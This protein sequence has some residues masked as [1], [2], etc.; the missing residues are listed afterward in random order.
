MN[1]I[2]YKGFDK[3][4]LKEQGVKPLVDNS[5]DDKFNLELLVESGYSEKIVES[6]FLKKDLDE[7]YITYEE[8]VV[9]YETLVTPLFAKHKI[10]VKN[11]NLYPDIYPI[12]VEINKDVFEKYQNAKDSDKDAVG[13]DKEIRRLFRFYS[14]IYYVNGRFYVSYHNNEI[15][16]GHVE[17]VDYYDNDVVVGESD[18][19]SG[20]DYFFDICDEPERYIECLDELSDKETSVIAYRDVEKTEVTKEA[21][22][23]LKAFCR[24][25]DKK[26]IKLIDAPNSHVAVRNELFDIT[27]MMIESNGGVFKGFKEFKIYKNPKISNETEPVS[28]G[29]VMEIIAREAENAAEGRMYRDIFFTAPTGAGKSM[30][31]QAPA[32]YIAD[33]YGKL[34]IIIEPLKSLMKDQVD[35]LRK[36]YGNKVDYINSDVATPADRD[37]IIEGIKNGRINI[38]YVSPETLISRT[39][40]S[41]VGEREIG[42]L[43][44]DEAHIVTAW[45]MG[46]RPDYWYL[47]AYINRLR[48]ERNG[49]GIIKEG[50]RIDKF[51]IFAC[52]ATAVNGG[53]DDT[54]SET[55]ISLTMND[56]IV[57]L[58]Y[59]RRDDDIKFDIR[60]HLD[61]KYTKNEYRVDKADNLETSLIKWHEDGKKTIIYTPYRSI[62]EKMKNASGEFESFQKFSDLTGIYTGGGDDPNQKNEEMDNF[63]AG[64]IKTMFA[65]KAFGMGVDIKDVD[66]VYHYA[67]TGSLADYVQEIGRVARKEGMI[68]LATTD[69]YSHDME[70]IDA[71]YGMSQITKTHIMQCLRIIYDAY[72]QKGYRQRFVISPSMFNSV[73]VAGRNEDRDKTIEAKLKIALLMIEKDLRNTY[74][75]PV[76]VSRPGTVFTNSYVQVAEP[77]LND[78][79]GSKYS[80]YFTEKARYSDGLNKYTVFEVNLSGI[81]EDERFGYDRMSFPEFKYH[82]YNYKNE[83]DPD[84]KVMSEISMYYIPQALLNLEAKA[85]GVEKLYDLAKQHIG[86]VIEC[87]STFGGRYF[88]I[89]EFSKKL[90]SGSNAMKYN[91]MQA[92]SIANSFFSVVDPYEHCVRSRI[93]PKNQIIEYSVTNGNLRNM[94]EAILEQSQLIRDMMKSYGEKYSRFIPLE[95]KKDSDALKLLSLFDIASYTVE[96][97]N[98]PQISIWLNSPDRIKQIV[99]GRIQYNN[100]YVKRAAEKHRRSVKIL[101]HFFEN[102]KTD[103]ERWD[104]IER[105]FL[106]EDVLSEIKSVST[107]NP[108]IKVQPIVNYIVPG[109]GVDLADMYKTWEEF[110][111]VEIN[112][113]SESAEKN[114]YSYRQLAKN[115]IRVADKAAVQIKGSLGLIDALFVFEKENVVILSEFTKKP[116]WDYCSKMGWRAFGIDD[117]EDEIDKLKEALNG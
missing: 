105:Y 71:L 86:F 110:I 88:T 30:T 95:S 14:E 12:Q 65:T 79:L 94:A 42:L 45:G 113:N 99:T 47:G 20:Y 81:W 29:D 38:L 52:T 10:I 83:T 6:A 13:S 54:V 63:K 49:R 106:G 41:L 58:G 11:N 89:D 55:F 26:I 75:V 18:V 96:G 3:E 64:K 16:N 19:D 53:W 1:I 62:A 107:D 9:A 111:E 116:T 97:G 27:K 91:K 92:D 22:E 67:P 23:S 4:F 82:Y 112:N 50:R 31:F 59:A 98:E 74:R 46:F 48:N 73:F 61:R 114:L 77:R 109:S 17:C 32:R 21:I 80:K 66:N 56:P 34:V 33:K 72:K 76:F 36:S 78:V 57:I 102:L 25:N 8:F 44:I 68:G 101:R 115:G 69:Y 7:A 90:T 103:S 51:P 85:D 43:I 93:N 108:E 100:R 87:L 2:V 117:L 15:R 24:N 104:F 37:R 5:I 35:N 70:Y 84:K 60:T 39:I 28:Q 40:E